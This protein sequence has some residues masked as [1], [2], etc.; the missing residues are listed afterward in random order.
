MLDRARIAGLLDLLAGELQRRGIDAELFL[1]GGAAMAL[2]YDSRR[3]TADLDAVFEPT[4]GVREAA[5]AVATREGLP[6]DWLND[7]VKG[8]VLG[9]DPNATVFLDR[10]GLTV[11][12]ASPTYL[13][14]MKAVAARVERDADDLLTL[15]RLCGFTDVDEALNT[16]AAT[17]PPTMVVQP[18]TMFLLRE[19][20]EA[21]CGD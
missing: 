9:A 20:L 7:A 6:A 18:K 15:F 16:V 17:L 3:A 2:A 5:K 14:V 12:I 11:R 8:F 21:E 1:V 19:L 13:F 4:D 10:P